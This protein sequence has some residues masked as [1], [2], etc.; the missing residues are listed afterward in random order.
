MSSL[1]GK[2]KKS[3][4]NAACIGGA[5]DLKASR[6]K[7]SIVAQSWDVEEV[8][9]GF[10]PSRVVNVGDVSSLFKTV[11]RMMRSLGDLNVEF[12]LES[13]EYGRL[14][15]VPCYTERERLELSF[16]DAAKLVIAASVFQGKVVALQK[17]Q[18]R[19]DKDKLFPD[20]E[21][22]AVGVFDEL[23]QVAEKEWDDDE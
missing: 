14:W 20:K 15:L 16:D 9:E 1:G 10:D 12:C 19:D 21:A 7:G 2:S 4:D 22:L 23:I 18:G 11:E 5:V 3:L 8:P 13:K 6:G 17:V